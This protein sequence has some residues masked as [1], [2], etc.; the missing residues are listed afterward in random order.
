MLYVLEGQDFREEIAS[1]LLFFLSFF[2]FTSSLFY[3]QVIFT[4]TSPS[5]QSFRRSFAVP[6][7]LLLM[8]MLEDGEEE[9]EDKRKTRQEAIFQVRF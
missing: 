5:I 2:I 1:V 6:A 7:L 8:M 9:H 4:S 3:W